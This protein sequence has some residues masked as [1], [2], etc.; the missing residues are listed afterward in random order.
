MR[1]KSLNANDPFN[2]A[3][4]REKPPFKLNQFGGTIGGPIL[5]NKTFYF[6]C[7]RRRGGGRLPGRPRSGL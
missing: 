3:A 1:D 6:G 4:G 2:N 7:T 5:E